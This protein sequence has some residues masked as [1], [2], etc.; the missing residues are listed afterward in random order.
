M[1]E[2]GAGSLYRDSI[3]VDVPGCGPLEG[4]HRVD[5]CVIGGGVTGCSAALHLAERG[6]RVKL[7]EARRLAWGASGRSGGHV[8][9]GLG[10]DMDF[11]RDR[12]GV[13]DARRIWNLTREAVDLTESLIEQHGIPCDLKSGYVHAAITRRHVR[14]YHEWME[15]MQRDFGY[16]G[17]AWIEGD[18]FRGRVCSDYYLGG[19]HEPAGR[20]LDPLNYT[21]GLAKAAAGQGVE[22]HEESPAIRIDHGEPVRVA[23]PTGCVEADFLVL[24]CNAHLEELDPELRAKIMPASNYII[25]TEP[26]SA[27]QVAST[28]PQDD[29]VADANFVLDYYRLSADRRLVYGGQVSYDGRAPRNLRQRMQAK[30]TKLFPVLRDTRIDYMWGGWVGITL[31]R[32]PHFGRRARNVYF[33]HGYSGQG[34]AMAGLAGRLIAEAMAGQA[35]RFDLFARMRHRNFPGGR[36]LRTPLLVLATTFYRLRDLM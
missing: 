13:D 35:E 24:G 23:T 31:N 5:V 28:L 26:L 1:H 16:E 30:M 11:V 25:A 20:H 17:L 32:F 34:M 15:R 3:R 6:Y 27:E 22:I 29:A 21:L 18:A 2:I 14:A 8:L 36:R 9:P 12:L 10:V 33:A 4:S 7:L 19:V